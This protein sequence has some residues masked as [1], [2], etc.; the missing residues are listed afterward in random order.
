MGNFQGKLGFSEIGGSVIQFIFLQGE[1]CYLLIIV[2]INCI[3]NLCMYMLEGTWSAV[4][5]PN[6]RVLEVVY[7]WYQSR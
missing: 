2:I 5:G 4:G 3:I 7:G 1:N 6:K